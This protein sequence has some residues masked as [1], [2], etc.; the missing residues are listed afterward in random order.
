M[1]ILEDR[2]SYYECKRAS[3]LLCAHDYNVFMLAEA[4][5]T[6]IYMPLCIVLNMLCICFMIKVFYPICGNECYLIISRARTSNFDVK[7]WQN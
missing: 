6:L 5:H 1:D 2:I 4:T 7:I 3:S